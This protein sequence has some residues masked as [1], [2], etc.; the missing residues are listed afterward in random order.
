MKSRARKKTRTLPKRRGKARVPRLPKYDPTAK[1][2][3]EIMEEIS[4]MV[5]DSEWAK[6]P[7]DLSINFHHYHHGA[8]KEKE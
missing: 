1:P 2:I 4:A 3:W 7:P 6:V 8:P 5:P